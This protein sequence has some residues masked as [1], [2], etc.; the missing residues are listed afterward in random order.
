MQTQP[1]T[2]KAPE[3][4]GDAWRADVEAQF[5]TNVGTGHLLSV[6]P[7]DTSNSGSPSASQPW[8][9]SSSEYVDI[10]TQ[11]YVATMP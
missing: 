1:W 11:M 4:P 6:R 8:T 2:T 3:T 7:G 10:C 5:A 9:C